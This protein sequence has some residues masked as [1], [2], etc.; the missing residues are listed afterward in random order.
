MRRKIEAI[1]KKLWVPNDSSPPGLV[2]N[3][4]LEGD[5]LPSPMIDHVRY[6]KLLELLPDHIVTNLEKSRLARD[7]RIPMIKAGLGFQEM[8]TSVIVDGSAIASSSTEAF[9][10]P[11][12]VF[13]KN[14]LQANGYSGRTFKWEA[15]GRA[16]TL[17]TAAT[18]TMKFGAALTEVIPTTTWA[19]SGPVA[20]HATAQTA[21]QWKCT[22]NVVVRSIGSGGTVFAQGDMDLA[23]NDL[24]TASQQNKF[25]GSAGANTPSTAAVNMIADQYVSLTGKWSV[26]TAYSI[27]GHQFI[28]ESL[29]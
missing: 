23:W 16:T 1:R 28:V 8:L 11:A 17:T 7:G 6:G 15:R 5:E 27:Q 3:W 13:P 25:M 21:S 12:L 19:V 24:S 26:T 10:F 22:G 14:F 29:N 9:L 20:A 4:V 18:M 2:C